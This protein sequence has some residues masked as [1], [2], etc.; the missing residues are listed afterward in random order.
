MEK[1]FYIPSSG[2]SCSCFEQGFLAREPHHPLGW[3]GL[4]AEPSL[5]NYAPLDSLET[6]CP[7]GKQMGLLEPAIW[8]W[9]FCFAASREVPKGNM[10][11]WQLCL[12]LWSE[13][14]R[15]FPQSGLQLAQ[16]IVDCG[17]KG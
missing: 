14:S 10:L 5:Q 15:S 6:A 3:L 11:A 17:K 8:A 12:W 16:W 7:L 4:P 9:D 1:R 13:G 2:Y